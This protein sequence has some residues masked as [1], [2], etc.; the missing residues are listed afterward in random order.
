MLTSRRR[1]AFDSN[2]KSSSG[3]QLDE[4]TIIG[5]FSMSMSL[6]PLLWGEEEEEEEGVVVVVVVVVS[7][8]LSLLCCCCC[9]CCESSNNADN[10]CVSD[11]YS[12]VASCV[13]MSLIEIGFMSTVLVFFVLVLVL[14]VPIPVLLLVVVIVKNDVRGRS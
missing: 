7:V 11:A 10:G 2:E 4:E 5:M 6:S 3:V 13:M 12:L 14:V 1:S 9:C 8:S